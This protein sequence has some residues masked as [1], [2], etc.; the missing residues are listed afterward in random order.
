MKKW[1]PAALVPAESLR[2]IS[3]AATVLATM[4]YF[5]RISMFFLPVPA[6]LSAYTP[7]EHDLPENESEAEIFLAEGVLDSSVWTALK[8]YYR[9]P[10]N[11]PS[12]EI[13]VLCEIF[14]DLAESLPG[15]DD[16]ERYIPWDE[17]SCRRFFFDHPELAAFRPVLDFS[18]RR[19][20]GPG[21]VSFHMNKSGIDTSAGHAAKFS[22]QPRK[23]IAASGTVDFSADYARWERRSIEFDPWPNLS[24]RAGNAVLLHEP[25]FFYG[26]FPDTVSSRSDRSDNWLY[27][28]AHTWNGVSALFALPFKRT[29]NAASISGF[30]HRGHTEEVTGGTVSASRRDHVRC[31]WGASRL[32]IGQER[33]GPLYLHSS[34][35]VRFSPW[36]A[37]LYAG[38]KRGFGSSIPFLF[39]SEFRA[40][41]QSFE[42]SLIHLP[43]RFSEPRSRILG[44]FAAEMDE[45]DTLF[46]SVSLIRIA[47]RLGPDAFF[48]LAPQLDFWFQG[49]RADHA[50]ALIRGEAEWWK[51]ESYFSFSRR[52]GPD[53]DHYRPAVLE[54]AFILNAAPGVSLSMRHKTLFPGGYRGTLSPVLRLFSAVRIEPLL[55]VMADYYGITST[56][57]G[58]RETISLFDRTSTELLFEKSI[59]KN[60]R[61]NRTRVEGKALFLF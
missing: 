11:V 47:S 57:V 38:W 28:T 52:I 16:L 15:K 24:I 48:R 3:F 46:Q 45:T 61:E 12:G 32:K 31:S 17:R 18:F 20:P 27:G 29:G 50:T 36:T 30:F 37:E 54:T 19:K 43:A 53:L 8:P 55:T 51:I 35:K 56:L 34:A 6:L 10:L 13:P 22:F 44:R 59:K 40:D 49:D 7:C 2:T 60:H 25:G 5:V 42:V 4:A 23:Q 58:M 21:K 14:P 26:H 39:R 33:D 9:K 1:T 41:S